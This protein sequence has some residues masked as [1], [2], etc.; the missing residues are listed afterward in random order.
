MDNKVVSS[1][2]EELGSRPEIKAIIPM[3]YAPGIP[4]LTIRED[5]LCLIVPFLRYKVT[6]END[7]TLVF[8]IRFLVEYV[9]PEKEI[10]KFTDLSFTPLAEKIDFDKSCGFFRH[11]AVKNLSKKE[12]F[13]LRRQT[14]LSFDK[15]TDV[16]LNGTQYT[17]ADHNTMAEQIQTIVEPCLWNFYKSIEPQF[18]NKYFNNGKN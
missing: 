6:G 8:P 7:K 14:L 10:I 2:Y 16:L 11:D 4:I 3:G 5:N 12:Y 13:A 9:I 17:V 18:Y 1:L 15:V